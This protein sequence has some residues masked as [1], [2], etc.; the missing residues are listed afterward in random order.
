MKYFIYLLLILVSY[1]GLFW[2]STKG[3]KT[4]IKMIFCAATALAFSSLLVSMFLD[5]FYTIIF[6]SLVFAVASYI[7]SNSKYTSGKTIKNGVFGG[8]WLALP[9]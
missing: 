3:E 4:R 6:V 8:I 5:L 2:F 7:G 9:I 1:G